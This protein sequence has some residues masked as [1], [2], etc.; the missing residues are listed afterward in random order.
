LLTQRQTNRQTDKVWQKITFL[1][2]VVSL[3][4]SKYV[5]NAGGNLVL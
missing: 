4:L 5:E 3:F 2:E 1:A